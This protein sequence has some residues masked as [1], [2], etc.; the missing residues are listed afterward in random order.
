MADPS[1]SGVPARACVTT[2]LADKAASKA[3]NRDTR[4]TLSERNRDG[5]DL[6]RVGRMNI[7]DG[8]CIMFIGRAIRPGRYH[9]VCVTLWC[10]S[11]RSAPGLR[12]ILAEF[13][14]Y[15][16]GTIAKAVVEADFRAIDSSR[17]HLQKASLLAR[18][19]SVRGTDSLVVLGEMCHLSVAVSRVALLRAKVRRAYVGERMIAEDRLES[20]PD[21]LVPFRPDTVGAF[22]VWTEWLDSSGTV[23]LSTESTDSPLLQVVGDRPLVAV[24]AELLFD[25]SLASALQELTSDD[26]DVFYFDLADQDR[27]LAVRRAV[28]MAGAPL[29]A[30]VVHP[31]DGAEVRT[32]GVDFRPVF[33]TA[34]LRRLAAAGAQIG[35]VVTRARAARL[36]AG[37][38][39]IPTFDPDAL[40]SLAH[41]LR[42]DGPRVV[43]HAPKRPSLADR[44]DRM[45]RTRSVSGNACHVETDNAQARRRL[46]DALENASST[47]HMQSYLVR[48]GVFVDQL[49]ARLIR[50]ARRGVMIR[51]FVD[52]VLG[53]SNTL[54]RGLAELPSVEVIYARLVAS[55]EDIETLQLKRRNHRKIVVVDGR[56]AF[57][58]GRNLADE[59][60]TGFDEIAITDWTPH[61][62]I[63]WFDA[64]VEVRGPLVQSVQDSFAASWTAAGGSTIPVDE[65]SFPAL[66]PAGSSRARLVLHEG[67][68]D[69]SAMLG[70]EAIIDGAQRHVYIVNDFPIVPSLQLAIRRALA[71]GVGITILTGNGVARR[72]DGTFLEGPL[73]R[74]AFEHMTKQRLEPLVR[75]GVRAV[76]Y[77][78]PPHP[79]VVCRGGTVRPYVH[80]KIMTA[81]GEVASI[82]SANLDAA[83]SYWEREAN[84]VIEDAEV[85]SRLEAELAHACETGHP[86]DPASADWR[87]ESLLRELASQ[88]WPESLYS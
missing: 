68:D 21:P 40:D 26:Y 75:A 58:S 8:V 11:D 44:L 6:P 53:T 1:A 49:G 4:P 86:I 9:D 62:R 85:A 82:G 54:V 43:P 27:T 31:R 18:L 65:A 7:M 69:A 45:T 59:Y 56:L 41:A 15:R 50:A 12:E 83:A 79:F 3:T 42:S 48:D 46:F 5:R 47:I 70:Y 84:I 14:R 55:R 67:V 2:E 64:H 74:E 34:T 29:A 38:A 33:M 36:A 81:D 80:A 30:V 24:D 20:P 22:A 28:A 13:R 61:Q 63:P 87:R 52:G 23:F 35:A 37:R 60:Y 51:L 66:E 57:V 71:R 76:E 17:G 32:L 88:L 78:P 16:D 25:D 39:D 73:Y 19:L 10:V 77:V 72:G